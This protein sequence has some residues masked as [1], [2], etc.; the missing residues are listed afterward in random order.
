LNLQTDLSFITLVTQA[1]V[2]VQAVLLLL[3]A[4]SLWSWWQ[5]F[6]KMFQLNAPRRTPTFS[7]T[8]SGRAAT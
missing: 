6:L 8:S 2:V 7:R 5:I 4:A 1:S 3:V